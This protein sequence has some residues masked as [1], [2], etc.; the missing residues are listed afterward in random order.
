MQSWQEEWEIFSQEAA[1]A[2]KT[3]EVE[4]TRIQHTERMIQQLEQRIAVLKNDAAQFDFSVA[5]DELQSLLM[6]KET[7]E[8]N[9][10]EQQSELENITQQLQHQRE[11]NRS[12]NAEWDDARSDLQEAK[13][14]YAS[15]NALQQAALGQNDHQVKHWLEKN[16]VA[17]DVRL[18]KK[19][20]VEPGWE[21]AAQT[22]L[23]AHLEAICVDSFDSVKHFL[24]DFPGGQ[25]EFFIAN[26]DNN[27][28]H[29]ADRLSSKVKASSNVTDILSRVYCAD[30]LES[31]LALAKNL[32]AESSV[33]TKDGLWLSRAWLRVSKDQDKQVGVL[34]REKELE[35][36]TSTLKELEKRVEF[37]EQ[38]LEEGKEKLT[39]LEIQRE[40]VQQLVNGAAQ[41]FSE[42]KVKVRVHQ[43]QLQQG[44]ERSK[45]VAD[46]LTER[47]QLLV[48]QQNTLRESRHLW[49]KALTTSEEFSHKKG[50]LENL[51]QQCREQL[52]MVREQ[53]RDANDQKHQMEV[54]VEQI[55]P[56][57][58]SLE[59]NIERTDK[60]LHSLLERLEV[61]SASLDEGEEPVIELQENLGK[62]LSERVI[63][64]NEMKAVRQQVETVVHGIR[65]LES[66]KDDIV[67]Q[68]E[69]ARRSL[70]EKRLDVRTLEVRKTQY[71]EQLTE[72]ECTFEAI[73][74]EMPEGANI[75][76]WAEEAE[77]IASRIQRL[78]PINLAAIDEY[79][80]EEERK[81]YLDAQYNDLIEALTTLENAIQ[82]IDKETRAKFKETF[83]KVNEHFQ[84]LFPLIFGGGSAYLELVGDDL[85]DTGVTVMAR[86][87]GKKNTSIHLLSGGEKALTAVALVFSI[88]QLNPAPFCILDE[89]DAPLDD[90]N[91][92]RFCKLVKE[93]SEKV[94]FLFISHNKIA[95]EMADQLTG[96][97]MH[98]PGV[99]RIVAVDMEE[100]VKLATA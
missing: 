60:Q 48:E 4:Q 30:N 64:E 77:R 68:V 74:A 36:V 55:R 81:Q 91:V 85:L 31:A 89:V 2:I 73:L 32:D 25:C 63:V 61:L 15:L 7:S 94:Q 12:L 51:G 78:G 83:D 53:V 11:M 40:E 45:R 90:A 69:N 37:I 58:Q 3:A 20:T 57:I 100:A 96:V 99:S 16:G 76:A 10:E 59:S 5:D 8:Q 88:F 84:A 29:A 21:V 33:I 9:L 70:E 93:M 79:K 13:G 75:A 34:Q 47:E 92:G 17:D 65:E 6:E 95:I 28:H 97:T 62:K 38:S 66:S 41:I 19:M 87:P 1:G 22:V 44:L 56:Q 71:Q 49:Q 86:P 43:D 67:L 54:R 27:A 52:S 82:K 39:D 42:S 72:L 18:A 98:E 26:N 14:R 24:S 35:E 50:S 23:G 80:V 46:E